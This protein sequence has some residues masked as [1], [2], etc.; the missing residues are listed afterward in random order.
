[1]AVFAC[2]TLLISQSFTSRWRLVPIAVGIGLAL[3]V[4]LTRPYLGVHYPLD[5]LAGWIAG[6]GCALLVSGLA[7]PRAPT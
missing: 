1:M 3:L 7:L 2:I 6:L 5:V 4:G